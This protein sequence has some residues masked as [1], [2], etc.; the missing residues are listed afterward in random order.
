MKTSYNV[1]FYHCPEKVYMDKLLALIHRG[2]DSDEYLDAE[3]RW[4]SETKHRAF[5]VKAIDTRDAANAAI[6]ELKEL[7][8]VRVCPDEDE[9]SGY[10][11]LDGEAYYECEIETAPRHHSVYSGF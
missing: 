1:E 5:V 10:L 3:D 6:R 7:G 8:A 4:W 11:L 9:Y 2:V